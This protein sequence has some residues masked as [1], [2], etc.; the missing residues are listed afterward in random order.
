M[1]IRLGL[2]K[3]DGTTNGTTPIKTIDTGIANPYGKFLTAMGNALFFSATDNAHGLELWQSDGSA[4]GTTLIKDINPGTADSAP[5]GWNVNG[6]L[7]FVADDGTHG[8]ELWKSDGTTSGTAFV[9]DI[10]PGAAS[11]DIGFIWNA[12]GTLLV[13]ANNGASKQLWKG[14]ALSASALL[15]QDIAV[16]QSLSQRG[17]TLLVSAGMNGDELW[18]LPLTAVRSGAEASGGPAIG[19]TLVSTDAQG[20]GATISIPA[21]V[22]A[23]PTTFLYTP[24]STEN[25]APPA[26]T[27][28]GRAFTLDAYQSG[29]K[30]NFFSFQKP[31]VVTL[32]YA[33]ADVAGLSEGTLK[34]Y[35]KSDNAWVDAATSCTP[36]SSYT[37]DPAHNQVTVAVCHLTEFGLFGTRSQVFLPL[38]I[39]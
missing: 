13:S 14:D 23:Q 35:L 21:G 12:N 27:F 8:R 4:A 24:V 32:T 16:W 17:D 5:E 11:A 10:N 38:T 26:F 22:A 20:N 1:P 29:A 7:F 31:I 36:T 37:R 3:S 28:A 39:R 19:S 25:T 9:Q 18:Q 2:W 6:T 33:D 15:V 34:L 30:L